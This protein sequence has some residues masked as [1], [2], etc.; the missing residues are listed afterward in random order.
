M[1]S[2]KRN[3]LW[4]EMY[5]YAQDNNLD[6]LNNKDVEV[7]FQD[8]ILE[9]LNTGI[10]ILVLLQHKNNNLNIK[11]KSQEDINKNIELLLEEFVKIR[12][13]DIKE[14]VIPES[15][16]IPE[17]VIPPVIKKQYRKGKK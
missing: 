9:H 15:V 7:M 16:I 8:I 10:D 1:G 5:L 12:E 14:K 6:I 17:V 4:K 13:S 2:Q 11:V 3:K